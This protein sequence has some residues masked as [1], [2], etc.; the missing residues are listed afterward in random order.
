MYPKHCS[1]RISPVSSGFIIISCEL[2][3][4]AILITVFIGKS[5]ALSSLSMYFVLSI[6]SPATTFKLVNTIPKC[7]GLKFLRYIINILN[8]ISSITL[9]A[10]NFFSRTA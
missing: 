5:T 3:N 1:F 7:S 2:N 8:D 4:H 6:M 9:C 10:T